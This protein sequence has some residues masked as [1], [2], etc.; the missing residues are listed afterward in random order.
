MPRKSSPATVG[1]ERPS[2]LPPDQP[3]VSRIYLPEYA[4]IQ[5][6]RA[7][8]L[9][10]TF[11]RHTHEQ[12]AIGIIDRGAQ[13]FECERSFYLASAGQVI[14]NNPG[15]VHTGASY[16]AT[17]WTYRMLY[18][19]PALLGDTYADLSTGSSNRV[20]FST[21][22]INEPALA[23][24]LADLAD[25]L[26][27]DAPQL[28]RDIRLLRLLGMLC[29]RYA[30]VPSGAARDRSEPQQVKRIAEYLRGHLGDDVSLAQLA[31][32]TGLGRFALLRAFKAATGLP[33]YAY[34]VNLRVA[35]ARQLIVSGAALADVAAESGFHDQSH[36]NRH[37]RRIFGY[38]PGTYQRACVA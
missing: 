23:R 5:V 16:A 17:G 14:L 32:L 21:P 24:S 18:L 1:R 26:T 15:D 13:R 28:E 38:T 8:F 19:D 2:A 4:P 30:V 20:D 29:E 9:R 10:Q 33:P 35:Y 22:V 3:M 25:V 6:M 36:L 37:F 11:P 12:F 31:T 7:R 34:L 27:A